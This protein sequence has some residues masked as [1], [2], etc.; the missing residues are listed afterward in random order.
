MWL[1]FCVLEIDFQNVCRP[2]GH[3]KTVLPFK[4][5]SPNIIQ[6]S[7]GFADR[8]NRFNYLQTS[9]S[10]DVS[11][12]SQ[13]NLAEKRLWLTIGG[14]PAQRGTMMSGFRDG[15]LFFS[16]LIFSSSILAGPPCVCH[17]YKSHILST[18]LRP[19]ATLSKDKHNDHRQHL[20]HHGQRKCCSMSL[21]FC[22][23]TLQRSYR[24]TLRW[25]FKGQ[26][27]SKN[28][29]FLTFHSMSSLW[30]LD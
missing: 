11:S 2:L 24:M 5:I 12:V 10:I 18:A 14:A 8:I 9:C 28:V 27:S 22:L 20:S 19:F 25:S 7:C 6:H 1:K 15:F 21:Y 4:L 13:P 30:S 17:H 29:P 3:F 16:L 26:Q 23:T